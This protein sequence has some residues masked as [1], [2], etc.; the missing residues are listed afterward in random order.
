M[1]TICGKLRSKKGKD[2]SQHIVKPSAAHGD[3]RE[4][5]LKIY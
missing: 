3:C 4:L 5:V 2:F 1:K